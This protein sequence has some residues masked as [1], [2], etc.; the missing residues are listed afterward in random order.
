MTAIEWLVEQICVDVPIYNDDGNE[1]N[2]EYWNAYKGS[3][4]LSNFI[5]KAKEIEKQQI[6]YFGAQ[7]CI[8]TTKKKSW[9]IEELY[10]NEFKSK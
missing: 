8:M 1:T 5:N 9:L 3:F 4:D 10:N 6:C 7:C 2:I